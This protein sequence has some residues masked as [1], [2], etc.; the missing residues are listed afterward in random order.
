MDIDGLRERIRG[1]D[2]D[3]VKLVSERTAIAEEIGVIKSDTGLPIRDTEV[4]SSVI[5][6]YRSL[7]I[8][9]GL[10][11]SICESIAR[12]LIEQ[13]VVRQTGI[14]RGGDRG[15]PPPD[16]GSYACESESAPGKDGLS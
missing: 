13:A 14:R 16:R 9:N 3:I 12:S 15:D 8:E 6:R 4:E 5:E 7:G 10:D 1:K 11:P 2:E